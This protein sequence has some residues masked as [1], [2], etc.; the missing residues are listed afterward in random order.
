M[1]TP[2]LVKIVEKMNP[3]W[4]KLFISY[5][6]SLLTYKVKDLCLI[7]K[8]FDLFLVYGIRVIRVLLSRILKNEE[9]FILNKYGE[10]KELL[11]YL[12]TDIVV[13]YFNKHSTTM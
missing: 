1:E 9:K 4:G 10:G 3:D 5:Y 12:G 11:A 2:E 8:I 6:K 13:E 7:G